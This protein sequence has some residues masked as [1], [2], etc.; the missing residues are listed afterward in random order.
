MLC[1]FTACRKDRIELLWTEQKS[2]TNLT[3]NG[4]H[5]IDENK[6]YAVGGDSWYLGIVL[7]TQDG[8]TTWQI[9]SL[10]NKQVFGLYFD[11]EERGYA[12]GIDGYVFT[13]E[14][15]EDWLFHRFYSW[16]IMRDIAFFDKNNGVTVGGV[17]YKTGIIQHF[18]DGFV[19]DTFIQTNYELSGVCYSD[20]NTVHAVG[21]GAVIRSTDGGY[22]WELNA[23][24]GDFFRSV[25]FPTS[26]VGYAVGYTGT[27]IK[28]TDSGENWTK[29]RKGNRQLSKDVAFRSV[30]FVD[31][32]KGYIVG[33]KGAFWMTNNGGD[34]WQ[35]VDNMPTSIDFHDVFVIRNQ[36]WIVGS[37]GKIYHFQD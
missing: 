23:I 27:I 21:Y 24:E 35:I 22:H 25:H 17:A 3:L 15:A 18:M 26:S 36:G 14:P 11:Q 2:N 1:C 13:K 8:G 34:D 29:I 19:Q 10:T 33:D 37:N 9:D 5:F 32:N 16:E 4:V 28:S 7:N 12:T 20:A 30:Y 31:E 6:G